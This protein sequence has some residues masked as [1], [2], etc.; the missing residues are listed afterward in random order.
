MAIQVQMIVAVAVNYT[1]TLDTVGLAQA[2]VIM[3]SKY[4][5][6]YK[7]QYFLI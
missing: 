3:Q 1:K 4:T 6:E 2:G 7:R 5:A